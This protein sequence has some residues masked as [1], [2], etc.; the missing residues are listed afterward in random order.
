MKYL[1]GVKHNYKVGQK[2]EFTD[3]VQSGM[4]ET[5]EGVIWEINE[6]G[7]LWVRTNSKGR[8]E[9][10]VLP[11]EVI[12]I[13][14]ENIKTMDNKVIYVYSPYDGEMVYFEEVKPGV[15][16]RIEEESKTNQS[17]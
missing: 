1:H 13:I 12:R 4:P 11:N 3:R 9:L 14:K 5:R 10:S 6:F 7:N 8:G 17:E 15:W 16:V 2:I